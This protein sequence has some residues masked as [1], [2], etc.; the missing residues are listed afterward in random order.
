MDAGHLRRLKGG[1]FAL[2]YACDSS[3][4][5]KQFAKHDRRCYQNEYP[6][7]PRVR[8]F[9]RPPS[10]S[11]AFP[12]NSC[13]PD[14]TGGKNTDLQFPGFTVTRKAIPI[15][16][17]DDVERIAIGRSLHIIRYT[18]GKRATRQRVQGTYDGHIHQQGLKQQS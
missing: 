5:S 2:T 9:P 1:T 17:L 13:A 12:R 4:E 18:L 10:E 16:R 14:L 7:K 11:Q 15:D 6:D 8:S 3:L